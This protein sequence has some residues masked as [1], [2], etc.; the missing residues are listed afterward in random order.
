MF[1]VVNSLKDE[2]LY[3]N[4]L[5]DPTPV[6][7]RDVTKALAPEREQTSKLCNL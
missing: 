7:Q 1:V 2:V 3:K 5:R 6:S 4:C